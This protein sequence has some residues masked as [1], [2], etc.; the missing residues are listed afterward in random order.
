MIIKCDVRFDPLWYNKTLT[1]WLKKSCIPK[2]KN[3]LTNMD[4]STDT[5]K[6]QLSRAKFAQKL[7]FFARGNFTPFISTSFQIWE[8]FIP[9]LFP[10]D[11]EY[12]II[13][14]I[15]LWEVGAK[16]RFN[17]TSKVNRRTYGRT[18]WQIFRLIERIG[19]KGQFFENLSL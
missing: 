19:R 7:T 6:I 14:D 2:I 15:Q 12:L 17:G 9:L 5:K 3:L 13:L 16:R 11:S 10:K 4:S 1:V 8:H 18:H